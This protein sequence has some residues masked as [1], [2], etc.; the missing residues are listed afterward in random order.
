MESTDDIQ[1]ELARLREENAR[2]KELLRKHGIGC[3]ASTSPIVPTQK[4]KPQL[5]LEEKVALFRSLFRGRE[6]VFARRWYSPKTEKS[7]YQPVC[8]REWNPVYCNKK[9]YKCAECPNRELKQLG[10]TDVYAHLEG[11]DPNGKDVIGAYA[12]LPDNS[13][14]FLCCDFDDKSC[15]H[16]Y[17]DDVRAYVSVCR[18]WKI[19]AYVE[20]SRS[21]N[22]AHVWILFN[23]P[24]K[25]QS[26]RR[27]GYAILT[28]AME[29]EGRMS[30]KSYDRFFPNQD[31]M[32]EG[33]FGNLVAL[34]L[35]GQA[36]KKGNSVF[37]DDNFIPYP[38]Q[39]AYLQQMM[40]MSLA[41][42]D[43]T[44]SLHANQEPLGALSKTSESAPW[45]RPKPKPMKSGDFPK[46]IAIIRASGLYI[47][48]AGLSTKVVNHLKRMA[49]F[50]NPEFYAKLG[51]RLPTFNIPRIISCS[52]IVED[53]LWL[54]RGCE[55]SVFDFFNE[56]DVKLTIEDKTN[57][58]QSI[59]A[60]F[61]GELRPEQAA[62]IEELSK[63]RCGTIYAATAFG[64]TVTGI[65]MITQKKVNTL[66]LV[67]TKALL[68]QWREQL[69]QYLEVDF[70]P[71]AQPKGRGR[72]KKFKKF[73]ALSST[74]NSLNGK[75]DIAL[76]QSC[77]SDNEVKPFVRDYG[78][79]IVDE[80][81]HAPAVS[82]EQ[83]LKEVNAK[84]VYGLTATP[85]RKDGHQPIIFMQCGEIRYTA[86]SKAQ[87]EQQTFHRLLIPRF[88][89][90][91]NLS[92]NNGYT[93]ITQ[94]LSEDESRNRL[95]IDDV[96]KV[97]DEGRSPIILTGLTSHVDYLAKECRKICPNVIRLVGND[98]AKTKREEM[99]RLKSIPDT[100]PLVVVATGKYVGEGFD[101]PRLDT[102]M[103]ALPVSWKGLIA[104]YTG[105]LHR[106]HPGKSEVRIY[107]YIDLRVPI[108]DSMYKKRLHGYKA[109]GYSVAV[110]ND[111]IF[112]EPTAETIFDS[113][114]FERPFHADL[115]SAKRS[116]VISV[117]RL[118]WNRT[119]KIIDLLTACMLRG[120]S[121]TIVISETSHREAE[122]QSMGIHIL[123]R[124]DNKMTCAIIDQS[125]GWYGSVN[126]I[127]RSIPDT[128]VIR[129]P[130]PDLANALLDNLNIV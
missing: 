93:A 112:A 106:D 2:L 10:Y 41:Q 44:L 72:R 69:E 16:G 95:I 52:E 96:K 87:Q 81:H 59:D 15:E 74:E 104:Q 92:D 118:R 55:G 107:D 28:E 126:L 32:P 80:C 20:W 17:K 6:D 130:S 94:S 67:H 65:A 33:G 84:W 8:T 86:D 89:T 1:K 125:L 5:S 18:D 14:Y 111:G 42:V 97:L 120:V 25:A 113:E 53:Y 57:P 64:K 49:A 35:Q 11:K 128:N 46:V 29:R 61:L 129:M 48:M 27:L 101:L 102:L 127:G 30:F 36:R 119:P 63:H 3:E 7:G 71:V 38:D 73:G 34:P 98:S 47:S 43:Y 54:P 62:A 85:I 79:V 90:Y 4:P 60:T 40:K 105:R 26:A 76:L 103:L 12:I 122:L 117:N 56:N 31:F 109:V 83:V 50:K 114:N 39:W 100:E 78:M 66:I 22:G 116:I 77:I 24:I 21:G 75:I 110:V 13:C 82:F 108:C 123:H 70:E 37:V 68:D 115:S 121:V 45:E 58:G 23:E 99:E 51:M 9:K 19:P 124:S 91:R 88:T